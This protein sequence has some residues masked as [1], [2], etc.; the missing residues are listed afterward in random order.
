MNAENFDSLKGKYIE[1]ATDLLQL[2]EECLLDL[3]KQP[4]NNE[5]LQEA[6][7][8]MHTLKGNSAMFGF[9]K[10]GDFTHYLENIYDLARNGQ[11]KVSQQVLSLSLAAVDHLRELLQDIELHNSVNRVR[12]HEL[13]K[14]VQRLA[15]ADSQTGSGKPANTPAKSAGQYTWAIHFKPGPDIMAN[16]TNPLYLLDEL[17]E[18]GDHRVFAGLEEMPPLQEADPL[19]CYTAWWVLLA[20]DRPEEEI[21][22]VFIF[23]EDNALL[24][25][26]KLSEGNLLQDTAFTR[27]IDQWQYHTLSIEVLQGL[28]AINEPYAP[29][30]PVTAKTP[31]QRAAAYG[32]SSIRI[33]ASKLDHMMNLV[34]ELVTAQ[35][36][37]GLVAG[38]IMDPRLLAVNED[39]EKLSRQL[40]DNAFKMCLVPAGTLL[41]RAERLVRDLSQELGK[42]VSFLSEGGS[43]EMDK[44]VIEGLADPLMHIIRNCMDHGIENTAGREA[45]GKPA[46]GKIT[47]R[48]FNSGNQ[49]VI[50][51]ADDGK[52]IDPEKLRQKAIARGL[53]SADAHLSR[54][55]LL[56]LVFAPGFSTAVAVTE[57]SGRGVGMD[58]VRKKI[59]EMH[60]SVFIDSVPGKG[61]TITIK[62]PLSLSIVDGMLVKIGNTPCV[63]PLASINKI[64]EATYQQVN[65]AWNDTLV[66]DDLPLLVLNLRKAFNI[67]APEPR[68]AQVVVV[69]YE[70][71][72]VGITVDYIVGEYQA[73]LKPLGRMY[74]E[75]EFIS[76]ATILGDGS[77]ALVLD[78]NKVIQKLAEAEGVQSARAV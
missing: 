23:V 75:Q 70:K 3:E 47:F 52:G 36:R 54:N 15:V 28:L 55:D 58:V 41:T 2:L 67:T 45:A 62:L 38:E 61:T 4:E 39:M 71:K 56:N 33:E 12:H 1:E 5:L 78:I 11:L 73:V 20:T 18:T 14:E 19:T 43:T 24:Q 44:S 25:V 46:E 76:G 37:L 48:A 69:G 74:R 63:V 40:R 77:V 51:V 64:R 32:I 27:E 65:A 17:C 42:P 68:Y 49:V 30:M 59:S 9:E 53:V 22:D 8:A 21:K 29:A 72:E 16:G 50:E 7:R 6:F 31:V 35:A 10:I 66:V 60:G 34:S 57:L 26:V 13:L